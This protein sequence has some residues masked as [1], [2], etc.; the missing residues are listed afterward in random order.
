MGIF[1]YKAFITKNSENS[2]G[3]DETFNNRFSVPYFISYHI[4]RFSRSD[5]YQA[6]ITQT[7]WTYGKSD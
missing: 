5:I 1:I 3:K 6:Y 7:G 4:I 2:N